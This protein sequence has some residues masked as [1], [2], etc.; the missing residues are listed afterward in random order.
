M[1]DKSKDPKSKHFPNETAYKLV[2]Y[3]IMPSVF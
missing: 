3:I 1:D 2:Y